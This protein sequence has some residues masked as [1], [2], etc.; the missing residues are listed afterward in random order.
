LLGR[1]RVPAGLESAK[2][3]ILDIGAADRWIAAHLDRE[4]SYL[5]LDYPATGNEFYASRPDIFADARA[6]P[7]AD[8]TVDAVVCLEVIEHVPDPGRA[9]QEIARVLRPGGAAW[10]SMPFLYPVHNEPF[11]FQRYTRYGLG[12][13]AERAGLEIVELH[14]DGHALRTAGL[15]SCLSIA[16]G[17]HKCRPLVK[18]LL[19]P[20]AL[21]MI[22]TINLAC[23]LLARCWPDWPNVAT[24]HQAMLRKA[25]S[26]E[27]GSTPTT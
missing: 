20:P 6:L 17:I 14:R 25:R 12:R 2:G 7:L 1:R 27:A 21:T 26:D 13:D 24:G 11:D 8:A 9:L 18:A 19:L 16:G 5:A 22:L 23:W 3:I 15:I 10:I 4:A